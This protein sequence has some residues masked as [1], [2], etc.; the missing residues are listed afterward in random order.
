VIAAVRR[1]GGSDALVQDV[2]AAAAGMVT[3]RVA[4]N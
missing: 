2:G 3:A 4:A 1:A